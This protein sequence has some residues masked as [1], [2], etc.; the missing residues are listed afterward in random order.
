MA[1]DQA[2]ILGASPQALGDTV[3][4]QIVYSNSGND[5][6][7]DAQ[8]VYSI[9]GTNFSGVTTNLP[10]IANGT[11]ATLNITGLLDN[12]YPAGTEVCLI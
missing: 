5:T 8:F 1:V 4:Y 12:N 9:S 6:V 3:Q 11:T 10:S 2:N 7:T